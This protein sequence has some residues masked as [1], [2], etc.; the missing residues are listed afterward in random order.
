M[1]KLTSLACWGG[2]VLS[3]AILATRVAEA[4]GVG[5]CDCAWQTMVG[6]TFAVFLPPIA[7]AAFFV[8]QL[9]NG[10]NRSRLRRIAGLAVLVGIPVGVVA[11]DAMSRDGALC[12][13]CV[14]SGRALVS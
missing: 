8:L 2:V 1:K 12:P 13:L 14:G 7:G 3:T 5:I 6:A 11:L 9:L 10:V 4:G